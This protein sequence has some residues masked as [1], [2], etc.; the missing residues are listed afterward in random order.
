MLCVRNTH[1]TNICWEGGCG[2]S[3]YQSTFPACRRHIFK[4]SNVRHFNDHELFERRRKKKNKHLETSLK[5]CFEALTGSHGLNRGG[6]TPLYFAHWF[7]VIRHIAQRCPEML[8]EEEKGV[9]NLFGTGGHPVHCPGVL[10]GYRLG[11]V[12]WKCSR[13]TTTSAAAHKQTHTVYHYLQIIR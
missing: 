9:M 12:R 1:Y 4:K 10:P 2:G 8:L 6:R 13:D 5:F 7:L 11:R 3:Q